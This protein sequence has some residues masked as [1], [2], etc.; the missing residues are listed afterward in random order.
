MK[1]GKIQI[2]VR[3]LTAFV[4]YPLKFDSDKA[5]AFPVDYGNENIRKPQFTSTMLKAQ[6][7]ALKKAKA[8]MATLKKAHK[9]ESFDIREVYTRT[10]IPLKRETRKDQTFNALNRYS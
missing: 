5:K 2:P 4:V 3:Q 8:Y 9:K 6:Q 10:S 1:K 7:E